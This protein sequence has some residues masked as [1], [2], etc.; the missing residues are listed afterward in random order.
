V[1]EIQNSLLEVVDTECP[2]FQVVR[3]DL[4]MLSTAKTPDKT[5]HAPAG[6]WGVPCLTVKGR[7]LA[8]LH[9]LGCPPSA[10]TCRRDGIS[11][12]HG[13]RTQSTLCWIAISFGVT[14]AAS[15]SRTRDKSCSHRSHTIL[16]GQRRARS[17]ENCLT[18]QWR[19][20]VDLEHR[21]GVGPSRVRG[22][23]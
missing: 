2:I 23:V 6:N 3:K 1:P 10:S 16:E 12:G 5:K 14:W 18:G 4:Q 8:V 11:S 20:S 7:P 21:L 22:R 9:S 17:Q 13:Q 19:S 15:T